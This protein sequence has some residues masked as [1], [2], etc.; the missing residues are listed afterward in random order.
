MELHIRYKEPIYEDDI[1]VGWR[2]LCFYHAARQAV[3]GYSVQQFVSTTK[4]ECEVE[5][6]CKHSGLM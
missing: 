3:A 2:E 1:L 5:P 6:I 4:G